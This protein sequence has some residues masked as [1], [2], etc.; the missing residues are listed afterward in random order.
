M[1]PS[2][3]VVIPT[4]NR[5]QFIGEAVASV[6]AQ[7]HRELEVIVVD[8]GSTDGTGAFL[9]QR[10]GHDQRFRYVP[11]E[12]AERAVARNTGIRAAQGQW[13]AFLDSDD[14]W[15]P[16]KLARQVACVTASPELVLVHTGYTEVDEHNQPLRDIL[17]NRRTEPE[18]A[19]GALV[20]ANF[21]CSATPLIRRDAFD[22]VGLFNEDRRLLCFED[23]EMWTRLAAVGPIQYLREPLARH[24]F[25]PG[26]TE[27]PL[28]LPVYEVFLAGVLA[29]VNRRCQKVARQAGA[30]RLWEFVGES[31]RKNSARTARQQ[32]ASGLVTL[33]LAFIQRLWHHRRL[34]LDALLGKN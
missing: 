24:R 3:S 18:T 17:L 30:E 12:N 21:I 29:T 32:M 1:L 6:L 15:L 23:W 25:H 14:L 28:N 5:R 2:V 33:K 34:A 22:R 19:F 26:N 31:I 9:Q 27:K 4:Y 13:L 16:D 11:Q 10:F 8:D 20:T 7:S